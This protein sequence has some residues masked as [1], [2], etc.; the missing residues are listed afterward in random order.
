[1]D[2]ELCRLFVRKKDPRMMV[3]LAH[4]DWTLN[5]KVESVIASEFTDP[6]KECRFKLA[7]NFF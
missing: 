1:M 5:A 6:A 3:E 7:L 4:N 2:M